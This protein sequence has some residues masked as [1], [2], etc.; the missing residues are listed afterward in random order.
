MT[1]YGSM[2]MRLLAAVILVIAG[3]ML[4]PSGAQAHP[5]HEHPAPV[6]A[7]VLGKQIK[8]QAVSKTGNYKQV[9][10][11]A[12]TF[13]FASVPFCTVGC[14]GSIGT[15]C[16]AAWVAPAAELRVPQVGDSI[17][18]PKSLGGTGIRPGALPEP[19]RTIV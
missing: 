9:A 5:G 6:L 8:T 1:S 2:L 18:I 4:A 12:D 17:A 15:G 7:N 10:G 13:H 3:S 14:C 19:P 16:C 11:Q